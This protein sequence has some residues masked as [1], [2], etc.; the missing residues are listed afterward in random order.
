MQ[1]TQQMIQGGQSRQDVAALIDAVAAAAP[2][3]AVREAQQDGSVHLRINRSV[4]V[5]Q[6]R[7]SLAHVARLSMENCQGSLPADLGDGFA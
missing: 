2:N 4:D 7:A 6:V 1:I 3:F 5:C